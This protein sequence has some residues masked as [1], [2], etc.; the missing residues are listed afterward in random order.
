MSN[1]MQRLMSS[2]TRVLVTGATGALGGAMVGYLL[3][4]T[5][6]QIVAI[7]RNPPCPTLL[8]SNIRLSHRH[9]NLDDAT[10]IVG[11]LTEIAPDMVLH[12]AATF[13]DDFAVA[14]QINYQAAATML[15]WVAAHHINTRVLLI[16]SA[17]EYGVVSIQ[18]NPVSEAR[19]LRPVSVYG[20]SKAC[21]TQ[22]VSYFAQRGVHVVMG[23]IFNLIGAGLSSRLFIGKVHQQ[24]AEIKSGQRHKIE[25]GSLSASRD[26][27][28][29][30]TAI[31][32]LM[33]IVCQGVAGET[34]HVA[35]GDPVTMRDLL[36]QELVKNGLDFSSVLEAPA[37]TN[38]VGYDVPIIYANINKTNQLMLQS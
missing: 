23:R 32:Q 29:I 15:G 38:R 6:C 25:V 8:E 4:N 18:D 37:L 2:S 36:S 11:A 1:T 21:Q 26:Y 31:T 10:D 28:P 22:L 9:C 20:H 27:L 14:Q 7:G 19:A 12:F 35:S 5:A 16:G 13:D 17:A 24:I 33:A 30:D 3:L 34:Y